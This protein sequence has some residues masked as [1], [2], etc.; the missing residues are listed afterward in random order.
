MTKTSIKPIRYVVHHSHDWH[1]SQ[2]D[3]W[4]SYN[5]ALDNGVL[6]AQSLAKQTAMRYYGEIFVDYGDSVLQPFESYKRKEKV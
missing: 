5:T 2:E 3:A 6:D 4:V 1:G